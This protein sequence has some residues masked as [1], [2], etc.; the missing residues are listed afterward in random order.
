MVTLYFYSYLTLN[1]DPCDLSR[2]RMLFLAL[3]STCGRFCMA[4]ATY[5]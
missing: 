3:L 5:R 1:V 2:E 4:S